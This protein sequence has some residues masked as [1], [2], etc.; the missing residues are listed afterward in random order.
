MPLGSP[1]YQPLPSHSTSPVSEGTP[2]KYT[3]TVMIRVNQRR[4]PWLTLG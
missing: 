2:H 1:P 3:T 4:I